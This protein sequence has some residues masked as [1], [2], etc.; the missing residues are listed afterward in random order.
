MR[1][2]VLTGD[3]PRHQYLVRRL[4]DHEHE[5]VAY[6]IPRARLNPAGPAMAEYYRRLVDAEAEIFPDRCRPVQCVNDIEA[7]VDWAERILVFG[8]RYIREPLLG[9]LM[10]KGAM[11][12]H[13]GVAPEYRGSACNF[14]ADYHGRPDLVGVTLHDL[15]AA[16]DG[17]PIL[18]RLRPLVLRGGNPWQRGLAVLKTALDFIAREEIEAPSPAV[19][20]DPGQHLHYSRHADFTEAVCAEYLARQ[21]A[22]VAAWR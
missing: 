9:R 10:A 8:Y 12:I 22:E 13:A 18:Q 7:A 16:I 15:T 14:W 4:L 2:L 5:V 3:Q 17:G 21:P 11:N 19:P 6:T 20:Q 1:V